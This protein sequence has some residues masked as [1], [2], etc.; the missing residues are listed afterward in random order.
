MLLLAPF[1][2]KLVN[3]SSHSEISNF[4]NSDFTA[5]K[6]LQ[7]FFQ[8]YDWSAVK[9]SFSTYVWSK[10]DSCFCEFLQHLRQ[11]FEFDVFGK[12]QKIL[13][14]YSE[15]KMLILQF[16]HTDLVN[17]MSPKYFIFLSN[18]I[19]CHPLFFRSLLFWYKLFQSHSKGFF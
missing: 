14:I 18:L 19:F 5:S 13:H 11:V 16:Q 15:L 4:Q 7:Q 12:A 17:I 8:K 1:E 9:N 2:F 10:V 6:P 3:Y